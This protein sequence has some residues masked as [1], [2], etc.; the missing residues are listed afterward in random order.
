MRSHRS[1]HTLA[2]NGG[3]KLMAGSVERDVEDAPPGEPARQPGPGSGSAGAAQI[4]R[5]S[6]RERV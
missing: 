3:K 5:A 4:G 1:E 2:V 6:C